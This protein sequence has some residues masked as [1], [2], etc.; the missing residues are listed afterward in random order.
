M[1]D[2]YLNVCV[3]TRTYSDQV[4]VVLFSYISWPLSFWL[5]FS[6]RGWEVQDVAENKQSMRDARDFL[7]R[8]ASP[9]DMP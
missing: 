8:A 3:Y 6:P 1:I 5:R 9:P 7:K 4:G 2:L